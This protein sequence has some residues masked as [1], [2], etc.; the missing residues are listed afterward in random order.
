VTIDYYKWLIV[1]VNTKTLYTMLFFACALPTRL[2]K[3]NPYTNLNVRRKFN[4]DEAMM[5]ESLIQ[6]MVELKLCF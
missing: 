2:S 6:W 5:R 1:V 3:G 4:R